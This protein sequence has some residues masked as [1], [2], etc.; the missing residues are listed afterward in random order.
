[1]TLTK[2]DNGFGFTIMDFSLGQRVNEILDPVRCNLLQVG[3]VLI[4]LNNSR[5]KEC[6]HHDVV[7]MLKDCQ[8][9]TEVELLVMRPMDH[10]QRV[11]DAESLYAKVAGKARSLSP[12][13]SISIYERCGDFT[14][15]VDDSVL[16]QPAKGE[17]VYQS[18]SI[19][20]FS[21]PLPAI[22]KAESLD[23]RINALHVQEFVTELQRLKNGFGFKIVRSAQD[24]VRL[25]F[26]I[27]N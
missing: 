22:P 7:Q 17:P 27:A 8:V 19:E 10:T 13:D 26:S 6:S 11:V 23:Q 25:H 5:I 18:I 21:R 24:K 3:D 1:M 9:G 12:C 15:S 16:R 14:S 4:E 20:Q 2:A